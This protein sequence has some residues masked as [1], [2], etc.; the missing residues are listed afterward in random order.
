M[1]DHK[2]IPTSLLGIDRLLLT[3]V[4]RYLWCDVY[5]N[6]ERE[7][8]YRQVV[9]CQFEP[10]LACRPQTPDVPDLDDALF[11]LFHACGRI[12]Q[13]WGKSF[14]QVA[15]EMYVGEG[16][17]DLDGPFCEKLELL[18]YKTLMAC[19]GH[20]ISGADDDNWPEGLDDAPIH[21]ENPLQ[22]QEG[23]TE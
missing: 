19:I 1:T 10:E 4:A 6:E 14:Y 7:G 5:W 8:E 9:G 3:E 17:P 18:V 13:A 16:Q 2:I 21:I 22:D 23:L 11:N 12:E 15:C 20:G